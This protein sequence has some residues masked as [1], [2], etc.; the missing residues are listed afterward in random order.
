M[1]VIKNKYNNSPTI[2]KCIKDYQY[3]FRKDLLRNKIAFITGGG[4]GICFTIAEIFMRHGC[5]TAIAGRNLERLQ[6]SAKTLTETTG[7][8]CLAVQMDVRK[9]TEVIEGIESCLKEYGRIDILIN[10]AA[11]NFLCPLETMSFNAFKT[12]IEIDT[13][14]TYNVSKV[15]YDKFLKSNGGVII[16]ITA[17]LH[18]RGT[19]LQAHA[20]AAKAAIEALTKHQAIEWGPNGVRVVCV[21]P[22]PIE[23][24]EGMKKLSMGLSTADI[25]SRIPIGHIG[26]K[27]EI[28]EICLFLATDMARLITSSV[29]VAD[30]GSWLTDVNVKK[31]LEIFKAFTAKM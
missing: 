29:V 2:E 19:P 20:G 3:S 27:Q 26:T 11:G 21:A 16:N 1:S 22:G 17:T 14:G 31:R 24:T 9:P 12:V 4:S 23:D 8:R 28:G 15:A 13:L 18:Y 25:E 7:S 10:G 6:T 30:G 5:H